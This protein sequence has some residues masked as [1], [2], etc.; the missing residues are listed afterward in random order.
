MSSQHLTAEQEALLIDV[1]AGE[2]SATDPAVIA[3]MRDTNFAT[4]LRS[5]QQTQGSIDH[6]ARQQREDLSRP[7][8]RLED[9]A[10]RSMRAAMG[11]ARAGSGRVLSFRRWA[12]IAAAL[13]ADVVIWATQENPRTSDMLGG[14]MRIEVTAGPTFRFDFALPPGGFFRIDVHPK[15]GERQRHR[16]DAP[17]TTWSPSPEVTARWG[18]TA[19]IYVRAMDR[20]G[21]MLEDGNAAWS[22][23]R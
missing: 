6:A 18:D 11:P 17:A 7:D 16:V 12:A 1:L 9:L 21:T 23:G 20:D 8:P 4:E 22:K 5:L 15:T 19:D 3:A 10:E 2:R 14:T 13:L